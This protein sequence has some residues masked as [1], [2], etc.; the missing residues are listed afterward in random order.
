MRSLRMLISNEFENQL[1]ILLAICFKILIWTWC[2]AKIWKKKHQ[3]LFNMMLHL[4]WL[5]YF[6]L[7]LK[8]FAQIKWCY[9]L[10]T[11]DYRMSLPLCNHDYAWNIGD[12]DHKFNTYW[13]VQTVSSELDWT[14]L[15]M[16]VIKVIFNREAFI[17][18]RHKCTSNRSICKK[19]KH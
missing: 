8:I 12:N 3:I 15:F 13:N 7:L 16:A 11:V 1:K 2:N 9:N 14:I 18:W 5:E 10:P 4:A 19:G 17:K 6:F